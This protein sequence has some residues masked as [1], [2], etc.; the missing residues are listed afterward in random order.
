MYFNELG[1]VIC[2]VTIYLV[3]QAMVNHLSP[4]VQENS[5]VTSRLVTWFLV[6]EGPTN[7]KIENFKY[8]QH[9]QHLKHQGVC[10]ITQITKNLKAKSNCSIF[11]KQMK[12]YPLSNRLCYVNKF[13]ILNE[14]YEILLVYQQPNLN[15]FY[16]SLF[17]T[18]IIVVRQ[19]NNKFCCSLVS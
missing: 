3:K 15:E 6:T 9:L 13:Y 7:L 11:L 16:S 14:V 19:M 8:I 4:S 10:N 1:Q 12:L 18:N 5:K 17:L 2:I